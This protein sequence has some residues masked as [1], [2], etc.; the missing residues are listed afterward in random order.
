MYCILTKLTSVL[1]R[2]PVRL[3]RDDRYFTDNHKV[4]IL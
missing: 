3:N 4:Q 2:I 1:L